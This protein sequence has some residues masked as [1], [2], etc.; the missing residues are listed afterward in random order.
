MFDLVFDACEKY[1]IKVK[2]TLTANSGPWHI[3]TPSLLHSHTG[4][5]DESRWPAMARYVEQCVTRYKDHPAL[6]QWILWNEPSAGKERGREH[7][8]QGRRHWQAWLKEAYRGEIGALNTRWR[9]GYQSFSEAQFPHEIIHP[10]QTGN[11]WAS[12]RPVMDYD[13]FAMK[14]LEWELQQIQDLVRKYDAKTPTCINPTPLLENQANSGLDQE[15]LAKIADVVGAS[16]HPAWHFTFCD[17]ELFPALMSLGV[18][19]TA[20]HPSVRRV[21]VTEVQCG[22]TLSSST[23]PSDVEP[24]EL[25]RFCLSGIFAGAGSVTGWFLNQRTYD[26]E[27]GDWGLLD[28]NDRQTGRSRMMK[29][30]RDVMETVDRVTGGLYAPGKRCAGSL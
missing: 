11:S 27:A 10:A 15:E 9:T 25:A 20:S 16:Y 24:A 29:K 30:V 21:E 19:K 4:F 1:G 6:G 5:L 7:S 28:N 14:W 2:A 13:R 8:D 18:K 3:G 12:Y 23:R 22:N 17:R 26:C